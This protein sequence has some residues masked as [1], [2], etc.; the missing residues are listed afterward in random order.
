MTPNTQHLYREL[1]RE[2][3][4]RNLYIEAVG[5]NPHFGVYPQTRIESICLQI[6]MILE[7]IALACLVANGGSL[8]EL[9]R[10]I[11][12]EYHAETI[13][14]RLDAINPDCYPRPLVLVP[15]PGG[16]RN[17]ALDDSRRGEITGRYRGK[18][19]DRPGA[20]WMTREE[21]K[22]I[23]GRLG[24]ILHARNPLGSKVDYGYFERMAPL[25]QDKF[26]NL[27]A[28]HRISVMEED[29]MYIVQMNAVP[30]TSTGQADGDV[31]VTP[32][33]KIGRTREGSRT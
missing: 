15:D 2:T 31:A 24:G 32:F 18:L 20:D 12:K 26:M 5:N 16:T 13:L 6:R 8:D 7:N 22:E 3:R 23:Y 27:L 30:D 28:H 21:F 9:P 14:R 1:M 33:Q 10:K 19:V 25:W 29:M 17:I 4:Y 11:E